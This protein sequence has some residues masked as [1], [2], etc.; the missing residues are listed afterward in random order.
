MHEKVQL[1][2]WVVVVMGEAW[3]HKDA[4][5]QVKQMRQSWW[6]KSLRVNSCLIAEA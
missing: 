6:A 4:V 5:P 3:S 2:V 1:H